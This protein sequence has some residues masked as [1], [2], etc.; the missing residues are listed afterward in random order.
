MVE[1]R[2]SALHEQQRRYGAAVRQ[3]LPLDSSSNPRTTDLLLPLVTTIGDDHERLFRTLLRSGLATD[4]QARQ[5]V[6]AAAATGVGKTH[7]AYAVGR[8]H[9]PTVV[10]RVAYSGV[11]LD[12]LAELTK[13]W[14]ALATELDRAAVL[15]ARHAH[16]FPFRC[17]WAKLAASLMELLLIAYL[18]ISLDMVQQAVLVRSSINPA[19]TREL[20]LRAHRNGCA[21][22]LVRQR[23]L[24]LLR[25][26]T[27]STT[28]ITAS[29]ES[30]S[31]LAATSDVREAL[32]A[33][34]CARIETHRNALFEEQNSGSELLLL[35]WDEASA[36]INRWPQLFVQAHALKAGEAA[37]RE[38]E[39]TVSQRRDGFYMAVHLA[40]SLLDGPPLLMLFTGT[41]VHMEQFD[42]DVSASSPV[43]SCL[44]QFEPAVLIQPEDVWHHLRSYFN[45]EAG[46]EA[47][48]V[49]VDLVK[50]TTGRPLFYSRL[51]AGVWQLLH[52][53]KPPVISI[54]QLALEW[55]EQVAME[56]E[57]WMR[58]ATLLL[59]GVRLPWAPSSTTHA[60]LLHLVDALLRDDDRF[61]L[62]I[63]SKDLALA[64]AFVSLGWVPVAIPYRS[65]DLPVSPR[66]L[67]AQLSWDTARNSP[68]LFDLRQ[69]PLIADV[70]AT[71]VRARMRNFHEL[72]RARVVTGLG[73][74]DRVAKG[75]LAEDVVVVDLCARVHM[76]KHQLVPAID[77][78]LPLMP[79]AQVAAA[80]HILQGWYTRSRHP[81]DACSSG[82]DVF[83]LFMGP[84]G[85]VCDDRMLYNLPQAMGIDVAFPVFRQHVMGAP[86]FKMVV[87]QLKNTTGSTLQQNCLTLAPGAQF[88]PNEWRHVLEAFSIADGGDELSLERS[89]PCV[90]HDWMQ[91]H[92]AAAELPRWM[93]QD[94]IRCAITARSVTDGVIEAVSRLGGLQTAAGP[95]A[96]LPTLSD[97]QQDI[98][99]GNSLLILT[100]SSEAWLPADVVHQMF[101]LQPDHG[102]M[103]LPT[104]LENLVSICAPPQ[105]QHCLNLV[106]KVKAQPSLLRRGEIDMF[107]ELVT[108]ALYAPEAETAAHT[109]CA[110]GSIDDAP[111]S[112]HASASTR[113]LAVSGSRAATK[114]RAVSSASQSLQTSR[115]T[116]AASSAVAVS[117]KVKG[118]AAAGVGARS[119]AAARP[120]ILER[121]SKR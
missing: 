49:L 114:V 117:G 58:R 68:F 56:S 39:A 112:V 90:S 26:S 121:H 51:F 17:A 41:M 14:A 12:G 13:P 10:M 108:A 85:A 19:A 82:G 88:L 5:V 46:A 87:C 24:S 1:D 33:T 29:G 72:A 118:S 91:Y 102:G 62:H 77:L 35:V 55:K 74:A 97:E 94:W 15:S 66:S 36:L 110:A 11:G 6:V 16:D 60:L 93:T 109:P 37:L 23:F 40:R 32:W 8:Q 2:A 100:M 54:T 115:S 3:V 80:T 98:A 92:R 79:P 18:Q 70:L 103:R 101:A 99:S 30:I 111:T 81:V 75:L 65:T 7:S 119:A 63:P 50:L 34:I 107:T 67:Q 43:R 42:K 73:S 78:L 20:L 44:K 71:S 86:T 53:A 61:H 52:N 47:D 57:T 27:V 106:Q 21:E 4:K 76:S 64:R 83:K 25:D 59:D 48:P 116:L 84:D 95:T 113:R 96:T 9:L 22:T 31:M 89:L 120:A 38:C 105:R 104:K 69:E 28:L 45:I